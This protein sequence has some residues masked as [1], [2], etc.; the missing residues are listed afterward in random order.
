MVGIIQHH[1]IGRQGR[2]A[3]ILMVFVYGPSS[4]PLNRSSCAN[5]GM[6]QRHQRPTSASKEGLTYLKIPE[7]LG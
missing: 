6:C 1:G 4:K 3:G 5:Q 7:S 2:G